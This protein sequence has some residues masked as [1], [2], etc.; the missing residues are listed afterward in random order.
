MDRVIEPRDS[1]NGSYKIRY[2]VDILKRT[3]LISMNTARIERS[4]GSGLNLQYS[5]YS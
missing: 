5:I 2:G 1:K 3:K 4:T